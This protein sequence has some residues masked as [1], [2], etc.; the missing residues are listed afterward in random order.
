MRCPFT[1]LS[2]VFR[3]FKYKQSSTF[4]SMRGIKSSGCGFINDLG[5]LGTFVR[6]FPCSITK[7]MPSLFQRNLVSKMKTV[8]YKGTHLSKQLIFTY[9]RASKHWLVVSTAIYMNNYRSIIF[10]MSINVVYHYKFRT[11]CGAMSIGYNLRH[12]RQHI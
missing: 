6:L 7:S 1:K 4:W 8:W 10:Y 11:V 9:R 3:A 5:T 2:C 12:V